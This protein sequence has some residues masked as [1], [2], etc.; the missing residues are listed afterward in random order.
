MRKKNF[1]FEKYFS[2]NTH[3]EFRRYLSFIEDPTIAV[4]EFIFVEDHCSLVPTVCLCC[5]ATKRGL[6]L[7]Y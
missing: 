5:H 2:F 3:D 6:N 1:Q 7:I 4:S